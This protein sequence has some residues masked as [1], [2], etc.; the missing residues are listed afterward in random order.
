MTGVP[1]SI[2]DAPDLLI[3]RIESL[4]A[5][6]VDALLANVRLRRQIGALA[7]FTIREPDEANHAETRATRKDARRPLLREAA[8]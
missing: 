2:N 7:S 6:L 3:E 8:C 5:Q 1:Y 4:T